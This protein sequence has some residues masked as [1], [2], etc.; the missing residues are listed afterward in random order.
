MR[1]NV[2]EL[3]SRAAARNMG[4]AGTRHGHRLAMQV[5]ARGA[6]SGAVEKKGAIY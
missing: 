6:A 2:G 3:T 4:D 5:R 1:V